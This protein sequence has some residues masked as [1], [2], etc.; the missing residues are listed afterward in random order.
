MLGLGVRLGVG[1]RV[2]VRGRVRVRVRVTVLSYF[3][4][5]P[6]KNQFW[7]LELSPAS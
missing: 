6:Y 2:G 1:V 3:P 4:F 7:G 5:N